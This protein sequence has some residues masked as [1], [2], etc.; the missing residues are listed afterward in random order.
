MSRKELKEDI[1]LLRINQQINSGFSAIPKQ[2]DNKKQLTQPHFQQTL[3]DEYIK[4]TKAEE[5]FNYSAKE[6]KRTIQTKETEVEFRYQA[7][8]AK[9]FADAAKYGNYILFPPK[10]ASAEIKNAFYSLTEEQ[11]HFL[12]GQIMGMHTIANFIREK[13]GLPPFPDDKLFL[14]RD[15]TG[16]NFNG[17][18]IY[19]KMMQFVN[20][21]KGLGVGEPEQYIRDYNLLAIFK[22]ALDKE[23]EKLYQS[24]QDSHHR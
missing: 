2:T 7:E 19:E 23:I 11:Q 24:K 4:T 5:E 10:S 18:Q 20:Y 6:V 9:R 12:E 16:E 21:Q 1:N 15:A 14:F 13:N 17:I 22:D 8:E 3:Q